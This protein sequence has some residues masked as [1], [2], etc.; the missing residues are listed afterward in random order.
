MSLLKG[1]HY[2]H[3][4]SRRGDTLVLIAFNE[5]NQIH[6]YTYVRKGCDW[7]IQNFIYKLHFKRYYFFILQYGFN[8]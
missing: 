1:I 2:S 7:E 6:E 3:N 4:K 5:G 8:D